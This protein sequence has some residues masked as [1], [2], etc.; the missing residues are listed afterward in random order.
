M[1]TIDLY[2][3]IK[4]LCAPDDY[5]TEVMCTETFWSPCMRVHE[6]DE[7]CHVQRTAE[8][9]SQST[10]S[11]RCYNFSLLLC[12][13]DCLNSSSWNQ[14]SCRWCA[15]WCNTPTSPSA[16]M[17][18]H[19]PTTQRTIRERYD[20]SNKDSLMMARVVCRNMLENWQKC[21]ECPCNENQLH[22]LFIHSVCSPSSGGILYIGCPRRN[23]PDFGRVFLMLKY[24]DIT[25]NTYVQSWTVTEIMARE[26][27]NFDSCY[28]LIDY[29]IHI[30]TGR[31]MWFL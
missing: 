31:N 2:R 6:S 28:T 21:E 27:W 8:N 17:A 15:P 25:Q 3:V 11:V 30:K 10:P 12:L 19:S 22:A 29:Q 20:N 16:Q 18:I 13:G 14:Q 1:D 9:C 23:V 26:F 5:N 4:S 7:L 24:T